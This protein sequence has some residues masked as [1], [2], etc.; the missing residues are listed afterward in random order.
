MD[1]FKFAPI[2][3]NVLRDYHLQVDDEAVEDILFEG[4]D[5]LLKLKDGKGIRVRID[6]KVK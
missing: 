3:K 2:I 4:N 1:Y 5:M 6:K